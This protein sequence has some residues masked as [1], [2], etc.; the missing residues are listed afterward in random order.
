MN[1]PIIKNQ[2]CQ[3][4]VRLLLF[5]SFKFTQYSLQLGITLLLYFPLYVCICKTHTI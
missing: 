5:F 1:K 3:I 4:R 2:V